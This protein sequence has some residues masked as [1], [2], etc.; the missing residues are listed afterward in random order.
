MN[1]NLYSNGA[2]PQ[3][4]PSYPMAEMHSSAYAPPLNYNQ[5]TEVVG[6]YDA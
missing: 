2:V 4:N 1:Q 5:P 6:G 3:P